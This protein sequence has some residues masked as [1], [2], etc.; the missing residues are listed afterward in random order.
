MLIVSEGVRVIVVVALASVGAGLGGV[1]GGRV[2]DRVAGVDVGLGDRV[3]RAVGPVSVADAD[4][5]V[6]VGVTRD[7]GRAA[8]GERVGDDRAAVRL[9]LP[10]LATVIV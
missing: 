3:G 4:R 5:A 8:R 1:D 7:V 2:D 10:V 6:G 9:T